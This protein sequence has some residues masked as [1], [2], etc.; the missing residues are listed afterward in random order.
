MFRDLLGDRGNDATD[1]LQVVDHL[2]GVCQPAVEVG[3]RVLEVVRLVNGVRQLRLPLS[4]AGLHVVPSLLEYLEV[5]FQPFSRRLG[6]LRYY[7]LSVCQEEFYLGFQIF[8]SG[9]KLLQF[10]INS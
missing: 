8:Q 9:F 1:G 7:S 6:S 2:V 4:Y 5:L 3:E 10:H